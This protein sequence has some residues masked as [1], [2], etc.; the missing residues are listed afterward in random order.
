MQQEPATGGAAMPPA[1]AD[2]SPRRAMG[3]NGD[4]L[5]LEQVV[6]A[7]RRLFGQR[8]YYRV[9]VDEIC[10]EAGLSRATFYFYFRD[11]RHLLLHLIGD[12][13][14][15]GTDLAR[16]QYP[17]NDAFSRIVATNAA[18]LYGMSREAMVLAQVL[19]LALV[20]DEIRQLY[21][22]GRRQLEARIERSIIRLLDRGE[23]PDTDPTLLASALIGMVESFAVRFFVVDS[24]ASVRHARF[25]DALKVLSETWYRA[26]YGRP[27]PENFA[28]EEYA[29]PA[30][31]ET[32]T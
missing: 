13:L 9:T 25:V 2:R 15:A 16:R 7:G 30:L 22:T 1:R 27:A 28:Y 11:K 23:I 18:Y 8:S 4:S 3:S 31:A 29:T 19:S 17:G 12:D 21:E 24:P 10:R 26:V 14:F 6:R 20:D 5:S 32:A